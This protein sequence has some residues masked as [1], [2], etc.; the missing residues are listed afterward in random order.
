[1]IIKRGSEG[2]KWGVIAQEFFWAAQQKY[3]N[4]KGSWIW[5][6]DRF[7]LFNVHTR[8]TI[9]AEGGLE[10]YI[11]EMEREQDYL[12]IKSAYVSKLYAMKSTLQIR[13]RRYVVISSGTMER[14]SLLP[15]LLYKSAK[16]LSITASRPTRCLCDNFEDSTTFS[17]ALF[18]KIYFSEIGFQ[19]CS[20]HMLNS[21][22]DG[23]PSE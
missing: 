2:E 8:I 4:S 15:S 10:F 16:P 11:Y 17:L 9:L 5:R 22:V 21:F 13:R 20:F 6:R 14:T 18:M 3:R 23:E 1:M 19:A 7:W 12:R